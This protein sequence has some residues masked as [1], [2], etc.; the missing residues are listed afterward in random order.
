MLHERVSKLI[1]LIYQA[2]EDDDAWVK[3]LD[4]LRTLTESR[5]VMVSAVDLT[6]Q[7]YLKSEFYGADDSL[8][9][10]AIQDYKNH[11][12]QIDPTLIFAVNHPSAGFTSLIDSINYENENRYQN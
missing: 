3:A 5:F 9:L 2:A 8:F 1:R 4:E 7:K 10:E 12:H 6:R 11:F